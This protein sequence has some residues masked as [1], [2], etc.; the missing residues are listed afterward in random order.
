MKFDVLVMR[1]GTMTVEAE[2]EAD[3]VIKANET[4]RDAEVIWDCGFEALT[5]DISEVED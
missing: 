2:N 5:A 4:G 1:T 3:A